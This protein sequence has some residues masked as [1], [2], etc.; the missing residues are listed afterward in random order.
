MH[1][2]SLLSS[3]IYLLRVY[4]HY[5]YTVLFHNII[6]PTREYS[7]SLNDSTS[8]YASSNPLVDKPW[9]CVFSTV[10]VSDIRQTM[11]TTII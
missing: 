10:H 2:I 5:Y 7:L 11:N 6:F 3:G 9:P 1:V 4:I 8:G